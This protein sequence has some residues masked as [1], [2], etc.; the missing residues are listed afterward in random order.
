MRTGSSTRS[1]P[2]CPPQPRA[3]GLHKTTM[4]IHNTMTAANISRI[5][6]NA[7][8]V[9]LDGVRHII[10]GEAE[11]TIR[12]ERS[13]RDAIHSAEAIADLREDLSFY[14]RTIAP[15]AK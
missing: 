4:K 6:V 8:S 9:D 1:A 2:D 15:A 7:L 10:H 13:I 3:T 11:L 14:G 12:D 5:S